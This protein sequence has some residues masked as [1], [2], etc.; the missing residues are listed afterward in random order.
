M[1]QNQMLNIYKYIA[2]LQE[3]IGNDVE[4]SL[5]V[6]DHVLKIRAYYPNKKLGMRNIFDCLDLANR[7]NAQITDGF[8]DWCKAMFK[9]HTKKENG[10]IREISAWCVDGYGKKENS[11]GR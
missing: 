2:D 7:N 10:G 3:R 8:V 5:S 1:E 4:I 6:E 9:K 11:D